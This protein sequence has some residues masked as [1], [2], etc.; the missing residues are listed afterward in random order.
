MFREITWFFIESTSLT[1]DSMSKIDTKRAVHSVRSLLRIAPH[2]EEG[3]EG[4][5][6]SAFSRWVGVDAQTNYQPHDYE[7]YSGTKKVLVVCTEERYMA[8]ENGNKFSTGNHPVETMLP[9]MHLTEA[10]LE[11]DI[12]TPTG[13][14]AKMEMWAM[15]E[16]D[17]HVQ[18]FF[19]ANY[20]KFENPM[21]LAEIAAGLN[22]ESPYI[23]VFIPGGHGAMLG[24]P[25]NQDLAK[26]MCWVKERDRIL[27]SLCHGPA[28]FLCA[29]V[30]P[31]HPH[32]YKGY[33]ICAFPDSID[34]MT[35]KIGYLPGPM[36]WF[37]GEK[38]QEAGFKIVNKRARGMIKKDRKLLTGD[39]PKAANALGK[40]AADCILDELKVLE[41]TPAP[42]SDELSMPEA[43]PAPE[44]D[45]LSMPEATPAPE[46]DEL[47]MLEATPAPESDFSILEATP[48]PESD[49]LS[50]LEATIPAPASDELSMLEATTPAP[51]ESSL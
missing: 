22:D 4:F 46:S 48:A 12:C 8:M 14:S 49:E 5:L 15:P 37:P 6:P 45:E 36:P 39:S 23:A 27:I 16:R 51:E 11:L 28:A 20:T 44:S 50:M 34:K 47:S 21:S 40:L 3:G 42:E 33:S 25:E 32:P 38:L 18:D 10:G 35:P 24:L 2:P 43:T 26:L 9:M 31:D 1:I 13:A 29:K 19:K 17:E 41:A 30:Y 7:K